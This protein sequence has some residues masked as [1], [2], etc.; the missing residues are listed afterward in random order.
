MKKI[1]GAMAALFATACARPYEFEVSGNFDSEN[2]RPFLTHINV[3]LSLGLDVD[4]LTQFAVA[5]PLDRTRAMTMTV[6]YQQK[7]CRVWYSV[8]MDD[9]DA[10]DLA[11]FTDCKGLATAISNEMTRFF[12]A[13]SM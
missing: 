9:I 3:A 11:F 8:F 10:P 6:K 1:A 5:T 13:R 2:V 7:A 12:D 4:R